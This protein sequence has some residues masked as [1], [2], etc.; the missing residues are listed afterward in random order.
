MLLFTKAKLLFAKA[1]DPQRSSELD[2][3]RTSE[4]LRYSLLSF[5]K[6][7][8]SLQRQNVNCCVKMAMDHS[9]GTVPLLNAYTGCYGN[10]IVHVEQLLRMIST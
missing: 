5:A 9:V 10:S 8:C 4:P 3:T 6:F 2:N 7:V 1:N